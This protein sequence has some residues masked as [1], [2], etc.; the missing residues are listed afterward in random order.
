MYPKTESSPPIKG[1]LDKKHGI[2][3]VLGALSRLSTCHIVLQ[4]DLSQ[5]LLGFV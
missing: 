5:G 1:T 2:R 3:V 4:Y